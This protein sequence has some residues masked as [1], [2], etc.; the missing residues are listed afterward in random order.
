MAQN[1]LFNILNPNEAPYMSL[2]PV[3]KG[4]IDL[5]NIPK[6]QDEPK[7]YSVNTNAMGLLGKVLSDI[8]LE[9]RITD[10]IDDFSAELEFPGP[11]SSRMSLGYNVPSGLGYNNDWEIGASVPF[12]F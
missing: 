12:D 1:E 10:Y 9:N 11:G 5:A 3:S 2:P 8:V 4:P 6:F 7:L